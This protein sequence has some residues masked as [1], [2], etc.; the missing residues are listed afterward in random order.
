MGQTGAREE[1]L[2]TLRNGRFLMCKLCFLFLS[3]I[4]QSYFLHFPLFATAVAKREKLSSRTTQKVGP[5]KTTQKLGC[6]KS[7]RA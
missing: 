3:F 2:Y 4:K 5:L 1:V 7:P 6:K